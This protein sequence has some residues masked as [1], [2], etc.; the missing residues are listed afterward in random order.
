VAYSALV[1]VLTVLFGAFLLHPVGSVA[2]S[3]TPRA[4]VAFCLPAQA[5]AFASRSSLAALPAMVESAERAGMGPAVS[6]FVLPLAASVSRV[7]A[8]VAQPSA[9]CSWRGSMAS[10]C[11]RRS[12]HR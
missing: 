4:F 9:C 3:M 7:G 2:G 12:W 1:V 6:R 10:C 11:H 8:A 5:V